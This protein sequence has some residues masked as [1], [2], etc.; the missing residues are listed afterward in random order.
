MLASLPFLHMAGIYVH[1]SAS[2][3]KPHLH[4]AFNPD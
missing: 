2:Y 1:I 3:V 4:Q